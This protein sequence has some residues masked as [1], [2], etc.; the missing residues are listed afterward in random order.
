[1][2]VFYYMVFGGLAAVVAALELSKSSKDRIS[3]SPTFNA[4]KNN[5]LVVYSLMM[6]GDWLQ[7]PYVYYLYTTYGYGKGE[8]GQLFIAGFGSSML[9]GTIVGSLADKQ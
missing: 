1:M 6:A 3:T 5:Y 4:F 9:F 8:I 7:G 2:E